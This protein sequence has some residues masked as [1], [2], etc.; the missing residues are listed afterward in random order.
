[1][2]DDALSK[3]L[4]PE[5]RGRVRGFGKGVTMSK[6]AV[7]SQRDN[8]FAQLSEEHLKLKE[9]V[10]NMQIIIDDLLKNKASVVY[11]ELI[12]VYFLFSFNNDIFVVRIKEMRK[13]QQID[14]QLIFR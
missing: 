11:K 4:G 6:L 9:Q 3:V 5:K 1:M 10:G 12:H 8:H 2:K 13:D 14:T 7:L